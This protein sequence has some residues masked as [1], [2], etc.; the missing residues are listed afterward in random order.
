LSW[1]QRV[2]EML[3]AGGT[4]ALAACS[5]SSAGG[6]FDAGG[7]TQAESGMCCNANGDPCCPSQYCGAPV[8]MQ[9]QEEKAC[10]ADG[11]TWSYAGCSLADAGSPRDA[12]TGDTASD[13]S[14]DASGDASPE[15]E[16]EAGTD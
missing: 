9:C 12:A 6:A 10:Q 15:A 5:S 3:L 4:L 14:G 1:E 8:S 7:D 13:A 11:G 16:P 2:R